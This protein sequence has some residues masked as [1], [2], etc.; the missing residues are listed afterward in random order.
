MAELKQFVADVRKFFGDTA[1]DKPDEDAGKV[2]F[3]TLADF[4]IQYIK[5]IKEVDEL[6]EQVIISIDIFVYFIFNQYL[7]LFLA[8]KSQGETPKFGC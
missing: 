6:A 8:K 3:S 1:P 5:S 7:Q 2:F 4:A